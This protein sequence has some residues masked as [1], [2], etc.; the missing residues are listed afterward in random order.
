MLA[1]GLPLR[2][3]AEDPDHGLA[4]DFL[5]DLP[6]DAPATQPVLTG[7]ANGV[8]SI[9]VAEADDVERERRRIS[10]HEPYRTLLGHFR[11]EAG[12]YYW[13]QLVSNSP[14]LDEFR[15]LFSDERAGYSEAL[16]RHY[17]QGAPLDWQQNF[18]STYAS[19]HA[20][21]D[22]AETW[23]H[24]V[25]M[26][27]TLEMAAACGL[28]LRPPRRDEPTLSAL[29][30]ETPPDSFRLMAS[31]WFPL[32]YVLNNLNRGL[33]LPD[34]YPFVLSPAVLKKLHFVHHL[35][36]ESPRASLAANS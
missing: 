5:A 18:I 36:G 22:W 27:D 12:H 10:L 7:H 26:A 20:W 8:I 21:E 25:H 14:R 16:Q 32:T 19:S 30:V 24:Y 23:A 2:P 31:A 35:I 17:E 11:H 13:D 3:K 1:L 4:F 6:A 33:G 34:P 9:N 29:P 28:A 15:E